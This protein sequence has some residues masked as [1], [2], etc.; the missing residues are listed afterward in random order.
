[1]NSNY[2]GRT[3]RSMQDALGPYASREISEPHQELD[4]ADWIVVIGC[5]AT[6][7]ILIIWRL[8]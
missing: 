4:H 7:A 6:A 3:A 8:L 1:M 5:L 2:T